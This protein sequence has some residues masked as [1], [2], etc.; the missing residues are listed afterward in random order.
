M[1]FIWNNNH[2]VKSIKYD[3]TKSGCHEV[4]SHKSQSD[5][6]IQ[7][8][9]NGIGYK[10]HRYIFEKT[11]GPIPPGIL[12]CHSCDNRKCIN[13]EHLFLGT[14]EDNNHDMMEKGRDRYVSQKG[15][16]KLKK[17]DVKFI[18]S[19]YRKVGTKSNINTLATYFEVGSECIRCI[20]RNK[21]WR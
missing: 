15:N 18:R 19:H 3:I 9:R 1:L 7:I 6:Y 5:G 21:T 4:I 13:P 12:V 14:Y 16:P 10:A 2:N 17:E 8:N 11:Y 20:I